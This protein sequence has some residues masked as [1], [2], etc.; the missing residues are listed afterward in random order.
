MKNILKSFF[1][2]Y[3]VIN[4]ILLFTIF[5]AV[6]G[7][8]PIPK[9]SY[10]INMGIP[11]QTIGNSLKPYGL[12]YELIKKHNVSIK[13]A[14]NPNKVK[15]GIDFSHEGVDYRGGTFIIPVEF[16]SPAV[17]SV[18]NTWKA[19]GVVATKIVTDFPSAPIYITLTFAP[20]IALDAQN[21]S[22]AQA[23]LVNA[24]FPASSYYFKNPQLL[25]CCDDVYIM[26][27]ADP[28]WATHSN[29]Y[30][31]N[32]TCKGAIWA[33][34]HAITLLEN[35]NNG[36]SQTNFLMTN[37]SGIGTAAVPFTTHVVGS[38]PYTKGESAEPVMQ[39]MGATDLAQVN[40]SEQVYLPQASWRSSTKIGVWD[41]TQADIPTLSPGK[42]ALIA[43]GSGLGDPAR[44]KVMYEAG[45]SIN[46]GT[47]GD[48]ASQRA[49]LNFIFWA[50][51]DKAVKVN[52]T[53]V[54]SLI[55]T[56]STVPGLKVSVNA[57]VPASPF[58]YEWLSGS[59]GTFSNPTGTFTNLTDAQTATSTNFTAPAAPT[60]SFPCVITCKITDA[61]GRIA[62]VNQAPTIQSLPV[63]PVAINDYKTTTPNTV[64]SVSPLLNDYDT[65]N[66]PL[67]LSLVSN[68]ITANGQFLIAADG[69]TIMYKPNLGFVG[70]DSIQYK[71][72]DPGP[73]CATA[74]V[75]ITVAENN[76]P[77]GSGKEF[78][79]I[80]TGYG[81]AIIS[82][83]GT[84][85]NP[86]NSLGSFNKVGTKLAKK[87][88]S[89]ITID[90]GYTVYKSD[91]II[92][93]LASADSKGTTFE[94][95][96]GYNS[97]VLNNVQT[98]KNKIKINSFG[99]YNY[100]V[101]EDSVR[102]IKIT[103]S[104]LNLYDSFVDGIS[105]PIH[106]CI[107]KCEA[108][109]RTIKNNKNAVS[110]FAQS[111]VS[112]PNNALGISNNAGAELTKAS[113][114]FLTL[115]LGENVPQG[116]SILMYL[117]SKNATT[118]T[119]GIVFP[120]SGSLD[121]TTFSGVST[122]QVYS[123]L[124]QYTPCTYTV[125][126]SGGIRYIKI[127]A[128]SGT[129][130][131]YVDAINFMSV[132]C[133]NI[134]PIAKNDTIKI[135]ED[136]AYTFDPRINDFDPQ[137]LPLSV[138][139]LS[140]ST[141]G[142][143][144]VGVSGKITFVPNIDFFGMEQIKYKVCN[145]LGYCSEATI[146]INI[147]DDLCAAGTYKPTTFTPITSTIILGEDTWLD[148]NN[149]DRNNGIN[150]LLSVNTRA[151]Q[152]KRALIKFNINSASIPSDAI[153]TSATLRLYKTGNKT[154]IVNVHRA[155]TSWSQG[156]ANNATGVPSWNQVASGTSWN[157]GKGGDYDTTRII[158]SK[159][160]S[161]AANLYVDFDIS[162][163]A[164][165]WIKGGLPNQGLLLKAANE[166]GSDNL[167]TFNSIEASTNKPQLVII[168]Q[169]ADCSSTTCTTIVNR[170]PVATIDET[171]TRYNT[172]T[173]IN[174][175]ANDKDIDNNLL[176]NSLTILNGMNGFPKSGTATISSGKIQYTPTSG[177]IKTDTVFYKICDLGTPALCDTSYA[178]ICINNVPIIA[179]DNVSSTPAAVPVSINVKDNDINF[180]GGTTTLEYDYSFL[181][182]NG[183]IT[184]QGD[185]IIYTPEFGFTGIESFQY[186]I[187]NSDFAPSVDTAK[188]TI[189]VLNNPPIAENDTV[190]TSACNPLI[191]NVLDNDSD[192]EDNNLSIV[193]V[194]NLSPSTAGILSFTNSNITFAPSATATGKI[195][196]T[197]TIRDDGIGSMQATDTVIVNIGMG[198]VNN[199][200]IAA[201]DTSDTYTGQVLYWNV[202]DNDLE[203]DGEKLIIK[204]PSNIKKPSHGSVQLMPNGL[205]AYTP[206]VGFFGKDT[207]EYQI[208]DTIVVASGCPARNNLRSTAKWFIDV[209][210]LT[211]P[212][213]VA[214]PDT[215]STIKNNSVTINVLTNDNFGIDGSAVG[216]ITITTLPIPST[217]IASVDDRNTPDDPT[218][219]KI[220]FTPSSNYVGTASLIYQICD[221][222]G[223][224]DTAKVEITIKLVNGGSVMITEI[225]TTNQ[226]KVGDASTVLVPNGG[227]APHIYSNGNTNLMCVSPSG[228]TALP[229]SS[230][231][232]I[233]LNG[234][235]SYTA[236]AVAGTYYFCINLCDSNLPTSVC[237]IATYKVIVT[238][239]CVIG[240]AVPGW[241]N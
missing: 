26:P 227:V 24:G 108:T 1:W 2:K 169:L 105:F 151:G 180:F 68:Q 19:L 97:G 65:N 206:N 120:V 234:T 159:I 94:V 109:Y 181:P 239:N 233:N 185:S 179:N 20:R 211:T 205:M 71:I 5:Q 118:T 195:M 133:I 228:A 57:S 92:L 72:C 218:D 3:L 145:T 37:K 149:P 154:E 216:K 38:I 161:T 155:I 12:V 187:S 136:N 224:C 144:S 184:F 241:K 226:N 201:N 212:I 79:I 48:V 36:S 140:N 204:L 52:I 175:T 41:E 104:S 42:A 35:M 164:K 51:Q 7:N 177:S 130:D 83:T 117:S 93:K 10:I 142:L 148:Q 73:L 100:A 156:S 173:L 84:I 8:E 200:P 171:C 56:G 146:F 21:G 137:N 237:N 127:A 103:T 110:V 126:Q 176:T 106:R 162:S 85:S 44:G 203:P 215:A 78:A 125:S 198:A 18:I 29:L 40:G 30:N 81:K 121:G 63:A 231:L 17:L 101:L 32:L 170:P 229:S 230:N 213:P 22:I 196:F 13:W 116:G 163:L 158:V 95:V 119:S 114:E 186:I 150:P 74:F 80:G 75:V 209:Y 167:I 60:V 115:D 202:L 39:Y 178:I 62:F 54:P 197:Y 14:I 15:D 168:Y 43:F 238:V 47:A 143:A 199:P 23:F 182:Q 102:F 67:T 77:C 113:T 55:P 96:S 99:T 28:T 153:I 135:C 124:P 141:H 69:K 86:L 98:F 190:S 61:C 240:S 194:Q 225:A 134:S 220:I 4:F 189:T 191:I 90:L 87:V 221:A 160:I 59:G 214:F 58:K 64:V 31:W 157:V 235:Y 33:G 183:T 232:L 147:P 9:G 111:G 11:T 208:S 27:H 165:Q 152:V 236:P 210:Q 193:S 223:D 123:Y 66:D 6:A 91:Q 188:V 34:C 46:L 222:T 129:V 107:N 49:F 25:A 207:L 50:S 138:K 128:P 112:S 174:V 192:S 76:G 219:D 82:Q 139:I 45:H 89:S 132:K 131:G 88:N 70:K 172:S 16:I 53:G 217:G 122:H 166:G